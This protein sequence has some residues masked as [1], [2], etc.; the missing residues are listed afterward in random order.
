MSK[1]KL[2]CLVAIQLSVFAWGRNGASNGDHPIRTMQL[3]LTKEL[4][5][6]NALLHSKSLNRMTQQDEERSCAAWFRVSER[7]ARMLAVASQGWPREDD[8]ARRLQ[9]LEDEVRSQP[10]CWQNDG[11]DLAGLSSSVEALLS[12]VAE[13][14]Y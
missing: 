8:G 3:E 5:G 1:R 7:V 4:H 2:F 10:T 12:R 9:N 6:L 11:V 14:R 13:W